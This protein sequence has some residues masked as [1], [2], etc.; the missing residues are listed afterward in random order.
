MPHIK[1]AGYNAFY[2][3]QGT[4]P[5]VVLLHGFTSN[6]AMWM[7]GGIVK[8]L[9]DSFR[10]TAYDLRGHGASTAPQHGY[11]SADL[12]TDLVELLDQ[13][14]IE[15]AWLVG[16]SL[17]GVVAMH[18]AH[19]A[20]QRVAGIVLSDTYFPGLASTEPGMPHAEIWQ[21]LRE[22]FQAAGH[23]IGPTVDFRRLLDEVAVLDASARTVLQDRLGAPAAR[24]IAQLRPL[25]ATSAAEEVFDPAGLTAAVLATIRQPV[26]ALYDEHTPF[27]A[28]Q[29]WLS[30]HL[31]HCTTGRVPGAAHL[32][33]LESPA[34]FTA[35]VR[36]FLLRQSDLSG[37]EALPLE[38]KR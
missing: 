22:H 35:Q 17:G 26:L 1:L 6:L 8:A 20:P 27:A 14:T 11:T 37:R 12:A 29:A 7:F 19:R 10:V 4:G 24:W 31:P 15:R 2:Q 32:A 23:E 33:L 18:T 36:D 38:A 25:A 30:E 16:H 34:E 21:N 3:Q 13:L 9:S 5:D 28:T